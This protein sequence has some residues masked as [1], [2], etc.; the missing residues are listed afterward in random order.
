MRRRNVPRGPVMGCLGL[1]T[2]GLVKRTGLDRAGFNPSKS[3]G[4][5]GLSCR[6]RK[7][8]LARGPGG[9]G[10]GSDRSMPILSAVP[11]QEGFSMIQV[12]RSALL[13]VQAIRNRRDYGHSPGNSVIF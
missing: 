1:S 5:D 13:P 6:L 10:A 8:S 9:P 12:S 2:S 4:P 7:Q 3:E 11:R